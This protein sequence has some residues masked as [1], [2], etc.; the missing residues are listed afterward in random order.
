[1]RAEKDSKSAKKAE[2]L[3]DFYSV[4]LA[5][6]KIEVVVPQGSNSRNC[7]GITLKHVGITN[8]L[9]EV[10]SL[11]LIPIYYYKPDLLL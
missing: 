8:A 10:R 6:D 1:M 3:F 7:M 9:C 2:P 11:F 5:L 4:N